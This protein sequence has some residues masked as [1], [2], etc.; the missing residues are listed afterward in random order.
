MKNWYNSKPE[1]VLAV[2]ML[3]SVAESDD[4]T[5]QPRHWKRALD[6]VDPLDDNVKMLFSAAGDNELAQITGLIEQT[7]TSAP[8]PVPAKRIQGMY[9]KDVR[10]G[11]DDINKCL[12]FLVSQGR[13]KLV[14]QT[15]GKGLRQRQISTYTRPDSASED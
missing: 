10:N 12:E 4:L 6:F 2:A 15:V 5:I 1:Y 8:K 9:F 13:I 14:E 11:V 7:I 3:C